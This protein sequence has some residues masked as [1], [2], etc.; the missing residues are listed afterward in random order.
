MAHY[1]PMVQAEVA[2]GSESVL[3]QHTPEDLN[4][5]L[6]RT[7]LA[8]LTSARSLLSHHESLSYKV[9]SSPSSH[10]VG[11]QM[12]FIQYAQ[13]LSNFLLKRNYDEGDDSDDDK[14]VCELAEHEDDGGEEREETTMIS[15]QQ[16]EQRNNCNNKNNNSVRVVRFQDA[17]CE[18][19]LDHMFEFSDVR[20]AFS[21]LTVSKRFCRSIEKR[22]WRN[23]WICSA[24][25]SSVPAPQLI[26]TPNIDD[27][28]DADDQKI[29]SPIPADPQSLHFFELRSAYDWSLNYENRND[30]LR[31]LLSLPILASKAH[32]VRSI[33]LNLDASSSEHIL[34]VDSC[35]P[36]AF[37]NA[38]ILHLTI[39]GG[40]G[41]IHMDRVPDQRN[42]I[43]NLISRCVQ[44]E[45]FCIDSPSQSDTFKISSEDLL[46]DFK[47]LSNVNNFR[48]S[49][50]N[51][52][53]VGTVAPLWDQYMHSLQYLWF[54]SKRRVNVDFANVNWSKLKKVY[55]RGAK[56]SEE[57]FHL[58]MS[59]IRE[60]CSSLIMSVHLPENSAITIRQFLSLGF[61]ELEQLS[62]T[63]HHPCWVVEPTPPAFLY[64]SLLK[65]KS[66]TLRDKHGMFDPWVLIQQF[67]IACPN[68]E[69]FL[70]ETA[71]TIE[72]LNEEQFFQ[73]L[74]EYFP[75]LNR[76]RR[77]WLTTANERLRMDCRDSAQ[78]RLKF[79]G[80]ILAK[81]PQIE[82]FE[83]PFFNSCKCKYSRFAGHL[84]M[85]TSIVKFMNL[86]Q[87]GN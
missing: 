84:P 43:C 26:N 27:D 11:F 54:H 40:G 5:F 10:V 25:P 8:L 71:K 31:G 14:K 18:D 2:L 47:R 24:L 66:L 52:D 51:P 32:L 63:L 22:I 16:Q 72:P 58:M 65:L 4:R 74:D 38:K 78:A 46:Q 73:T 77:F 19:V 53:P 57:Q 60:K 45:G 80:A 67:F 59:Q 42:F 20:T 29:S 44:V 33:R 69:G 55:L 1:R 37:Q 13:V 87:S 23:L 41:E 85:E 30:A 17:V 36:D 64:P 28:E 6:V 61:Q 82:V 68:L 49:I 34:G 70:F 3:N 9:L 86:M 7:N 79:A 62:L 21:L 35:L 76:L 56:M 83:S 75:K 39:E 81:Y 50:E 15:M 48:L 12:L